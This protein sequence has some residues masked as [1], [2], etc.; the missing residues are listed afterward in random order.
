MYCN[1]LVQRSYGDDFLSA[2]DPSLEIIG[3]ELCIAACWQKYHADHS[4][5]ALDPPL[6]L[7]VGKCIVACQQ[8]A[9]AD[10]SISALG[11]P[12]KFVEGKLGLAGYWQ[13]DDADHFI[14]VHPIGNNRR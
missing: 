4:I 3:S 1:M 12:F 9:Y 7:I 8:R 10:N 14:S 6:K 13:S 11:P 2:L 5:F